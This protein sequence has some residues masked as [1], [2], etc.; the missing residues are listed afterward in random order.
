MSSTH[1]RNRAFVDGAAVVAGRRASVVRRPERV[2][3]GAVHGWCNS[4]A[5]VMATYID[6]LVADH[7]E[8]VVRKEVEGAAAGDPS[9]GP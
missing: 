6:E 1:V 7:V 3:R 2:T 5:D 9:L 4:T 8:W